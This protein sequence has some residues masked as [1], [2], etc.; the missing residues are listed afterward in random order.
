MLFMMMNRCRRSQ[1]PIGQAQQEGRGQ[2]DGAGGHGPCTVAVVALVGAIT[3]I[4]EAALHLGPRAAAVRLVA[5]ILVRAGLHHGVWK[6][7]ARRGAAG[8]RKLNSW[9]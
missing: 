8:Q 4:G 5:E 2:Q 7:I 9:A 6:R 1:L 3:V